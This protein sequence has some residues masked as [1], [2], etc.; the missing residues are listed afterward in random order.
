MSHLYFAFVIYIGKRRDEWY[1]LKHIITP[2]DNIAFVVCHLEKRGV[3]SIKQCM[4]WGGFLKLR[5]A[6]IGV[7]PL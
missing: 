2:V 7:L 6:I 5:N 3:F 4:L 1:S